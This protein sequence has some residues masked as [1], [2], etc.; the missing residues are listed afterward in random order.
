MEGFL[1][2]ANVMA[3]LFFLML[4]GYAMARRGRLEQTVISK[5]NWFVF[6]IFIP[7]TMFT[8]IYNANLAQDMDLRFLLCGIG[9]TLLLIALVWLGTHLTVK[10]NARRSVVAQALFRCNVIL[11]G[12][13]I[14]TSLY[15]ADK[16]GPYSVML[17]FVVPILNMA[18]VILFCVYGVKKISPLQI[19]INTLKSPLIVAAMAAALCKLLHIRLPVM[20]HSF[21]STLASLATPVALILLGGFFR[22]DAARENRKTILAVLGL[23]LIVIPLVFVAIAILM[24]FRG[25]QLMAFVTLFAAPAAVSIFPMAQEMGADAD[26]ACQ[27][28]VFTSLFSMLT[29]FFW[30][31]ALRAL[32]LA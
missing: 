8:N 24:G 10:E 16:V 25:L 3:P 13:S 21:V 12:V 15:G 22:F 18:S 26:L 31:W 7:A 17:A 23:R 20:I 29:L 2:S 4:L 32:A 9:G 6:H 28:I 1:L 30:I 27:V 11:L 14:C 5:M 19:V